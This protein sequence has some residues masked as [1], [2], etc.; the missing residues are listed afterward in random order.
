MKSDL[1]S[2]FTTKIFHDKV[3]RK[4]VHSSYTAYRILSSIMKVYRPPFGYQ[5][6]DRAPLYHS[7]VVR[8]YGLYRDECVLIELSSS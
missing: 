6:H 5:F 3:R 1:G 7:N 4:S 2:P 8:S